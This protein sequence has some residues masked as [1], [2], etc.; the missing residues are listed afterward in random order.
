VT[1]H[2]AVRTVLLRSSQLR[3]ALFVAAGLLA[4]GTVAA[5]AFWT[6]T[7]LNPNGNKA[8]AAAATLS[9]PTAPTA[10]A[11]G[12]GAITVGWTLPASQLSGA[13]YRVTRTSP[14]TP[15]TVCTVAS[16]VHSCQDA[17]LV[18]GTTYS[19]SIIAMLSNWQTTA[20]TTSTTTSTPTLTIALSS[21]PYTAGTA[22]TVTTVTA[23]VGG[24]TDTTYTGAKTINWTGLANSPS[25]QAASYPSTSV[26][27]TNGVASP[28]ST[29]TAYAAGS[30]TLTAT[31]GS[32]TSVTGS[33]TFTLGAAANSKLVF[34]PSTP[35]PATAGS[36][37]ANVAVSVEDA[38]SNVETTL[39]TGSVVMSIKSGS[40]QS[41]F[42]SGTTTVSVS[43]GVA[44]FAN[45]VVDTSGSYTLTAT[46]SSIS[47]VAVAVNSNAFTVSPSA[48]STLAFTPLTPGPGTAGSAIPHVAVSVEDTFGNVVTSASSGSVTV[49]IKSGGPQS[50]FSSGSTTVSVA[51]GV[52][53]FSDLVLDTA[54]TYTFTA[55]PS[56]ISGVTAAVN[57][58]FFSV[59]A[60]SVSKLAF[61]TVP[62]GNQ[63]ASATATLGAY[64]VQEQDTFGNPVT[65]AST[66][67]L[68]LSTSSSGTTGHTP[69]FTTTSGGSTSSSVTIASGQS[70][71]GNFY[72]SD[73]LAGTP[74]LTAQATGI[75]N[76]GTTS[77][78]IVGAA[79]G[80]FSLSATGTQTA[81]TAFN[82]TVS[83]LDAFG[84]AA[85]GWV[86][87]TG[88]VKFSGPA[89]SPSGQVPTY[90]AAGTCGTGNSNLSFNVSGQASASVTLFKALL[91]T[92]LTV[93]DA[94]T[95]TKSGSTGNFAVN[96]AGAVLSF[97]SSCPTLSARN[98]TCTDTVA[99]ANDTYGNAALYASPGITLSL[100]L[101]DGTHFS[102][103]AGGT[104]SS[105]SSSTATVTATAS[106]SGS[107][108]V[109]HI[110]GA[111]N[112]S[113]TLTVNGPTGGG[114]TQGSM[115]ISS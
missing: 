9:A 47:G 15:T 50:T 10:T 74:T 8:Q 110:D 32:A 2:V 46:P 34:T 82:E 44:S 77:P 70:T 109:E 90:P 48:A 24:T 93:K 76:N 51:S 42:T 57:S 31:D 108:T 23:K 27:F 62:S 59:S 66:V 33:V 52:A 37:I 36:S 3:R 104:G 12:S 68:A 84:N 17:G 96:S 113:T 28:S 98:A 11:N 13:Q 60:A 43:S 79:L 26:T 61:T 38:Y 88:C 75:A 111:T 87:T 85:S 63:T 40:P 89:N 101:A 25:G 4:A 7:V 1:A 49:S 83:A 5:L 103:V 97:T 65:A 73:T 18:A 100:A 94:A 78:T 91:T 20:I 16:S 30:N 67:T 22:I 105:S 115:I 39:N 69:F 92:N 72:Y 80:S 21:S 45:L 64:Q 55:T 58:H 102:V 86:S 95:G 19:Y 106:P 114:F 54:G 6:I 14:G 71:T 29:F 81:G 56:G 41:T 107:F 112:K 53:T 99:I 35:G